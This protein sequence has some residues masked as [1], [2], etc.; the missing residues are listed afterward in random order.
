MVEIGPRRYP[1]G[2]VVQGEG[3][4]QTAYASGKAAAEHLDLRMITVKDSGVHGY[5]GTRKNACVDDA[6]NAYLIDGTLPD[7][8]VECAAVADKRPD[9]EP[10]QPAERSGA[11]SELITA[12][13]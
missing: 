5:Y 9:I 4:T 13:K 10:G 1:Q 8:D 11:L 2:L 3:D 7:A 6:V 12:V